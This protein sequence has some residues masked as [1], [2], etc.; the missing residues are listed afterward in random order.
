L[1]V[2][3]HRH[4]IIVIVMNS[5]DDEEQHRDRVVLLSNHTSKSSDDSVVLPRWTF[6]LLLV[7]ASG[8]VAISLIVLLVLLRGTMSVSVSGGSV[9]LSGVDKSSVTVDDVNTAQCTDTTRP[10]PV[11]AH[12]NELGGIVQAEGFTSAAELGV[13]RG[14]FAETIMSQWPKM[15]KWY[16]VDIW[17]QQENYFDTANVNNKEQEDIYQMAMQKMAPYKDRVT[18]LRMFTSKAAQQIPDNSLDF[19]YVSS[20]HSTPLHST[21]ALAHS[22]NE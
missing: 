2:C 7:T 17:A 4:I 20:F 21:H 22:M 15:T 11:A 6:V 1:S 8:A 18:V 5:F 14:L 13:Q 10:I 16:A 9:G 12:R 3:H 19:I